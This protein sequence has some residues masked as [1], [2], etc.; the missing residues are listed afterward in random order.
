MNNI[1]INNQSLILSSASKPEPFVHTGQVIESTHNLIVL[2]SSLE[3]DLSAMARRVWQLAS[4]SSAHIIFLAL[5]SNSVQQPGLRRE[6]VSMAAMVSDGAVSAEV[7][8]L[9]GTDWVGAVR[10]LSK[11]GDVVVCLGEQRVGASRKSLSQVLQSQLDLPLYILS[12]FYPQK[13]VRPNW[14]SQA[15]AWGGSIAILAGFFLLQVRI[16]DLTQNW[17]QSVFF[18]MSV[19]LEIAIIWVWNNLFE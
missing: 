7:A 13:A 15:A 18:F 4:A 5:Y 17:S 10:S 12:G 6:L 8:V 11:A 9:E 1:S 2:V 3:A 14:I 16:D 19:L